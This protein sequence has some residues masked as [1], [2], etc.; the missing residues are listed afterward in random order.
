MNIGDIG[1]ALYT[2]FKGSQVGA[3]EFGNR[4]YRSKGAKLNGRERRWVL[5]S[6]VKEASKVPAEWHAWLHYTTD[7]PLTETAAQPADWQQDHI[8]NLTG[9]KLSYHPGPHTH[10]GPYK[11][12]SP[13]A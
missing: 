1:T 13:D 2:L 12:W 8:P 3:D 11:A 6:G 9:T 7:A 4:Y 10:A 5:Y